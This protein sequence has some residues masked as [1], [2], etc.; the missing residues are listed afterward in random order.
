MGPTVALDTFVVNLNEPGSTRYLKT[1]F[2]IEVRD[3]NVATD[4]TNLKRIVR[5]ELLGY[6]SSLNVAATLGEAGKAKIREQ[7]L[8][9]TDKILGGGGRARRVYFIDFVVQ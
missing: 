5:D 2:E 8:A 3:A 7:I 9:T 6:L 4:L 1:S